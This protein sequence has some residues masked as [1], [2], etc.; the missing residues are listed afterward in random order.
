VFV[1]TIFGKPVPLPF[2]RPAR[3]KDRAFAEN[4]YRSTQPLVDIPDLIL[5]H[6]LSQHSGLV[7]IPAGLDCMR[8]GKVSAT[9]F[10][11]QVSNMQR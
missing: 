6:P 4:W 9:K 7:D 10:V 11:Y 5:P 3:P 2:G 8:Q 1:Y